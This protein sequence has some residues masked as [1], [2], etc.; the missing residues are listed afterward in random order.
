M[1]EVISRSIDMT[2]EML[3]NRHSISQGLKFA[4]LFTTIYSQKGGICKI[5]LQRQLQF[6]LR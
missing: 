1:L 3:R 5:H 2:T 4:L 6:Q